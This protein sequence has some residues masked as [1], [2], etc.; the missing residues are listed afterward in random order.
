MPDL[1]QQFAAITRLMKVMEPYARK[2]RDITAG[3][4]LKLELAKIA[5]LPSACCRWRHVDMVVPLKDR[6]FSKPFAAEA[7]GHLAIH[8]SVGKAGV[9]S[10]GN[11]SV[12]HLPTGRLV[13]VCKT[14]E[15]ARKAV[16][17]GLHLNWNFSHPAHIPA[18]TDRFGFV[19]SGAARFGL[20]DKSGSARR[21]IGG[22]AKGE[23]ARA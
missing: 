17:Y 9:P 14:E 2:R 12:T 15:G 7:K 5:A 8:R 6:K 16:S 20:F 23:G 22:R 10:L 1:E 21:P 3:Q 18:K 19:I 13:A 11:Y 4:V